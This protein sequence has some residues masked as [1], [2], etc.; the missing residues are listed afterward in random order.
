VPRPSTNTDKKLIQAAIDIMAGQGF[1]GLNIRQVARRARVNLGMF[2]YH[3]KTKDGFV[4]TVLQ[5]IYER[6]Y[7]QF[8]LE[9]SADAPLEER[10]RRTLM[11]ASCFI[12]DNRQNIMVILHGVLERDPVV[13]D[14][15]HK[16]FHR[17]ILL[18][19][20]L[21]REAQ[22]KGVIARLPIF[23]VVSFLMGGVLFPCAAIGA[24]ERAVEKEPM[25]LSIPLIRG[26]V[27]SDKAIQQRI[28]LALKALAPASTPGG[29]PASTPGGTPQG[30]KVR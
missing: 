5:E 2:H 7:R 16:N 9:T 14:F 11:M 19:F 22:R 28:D 27:I 24:I 21:I 13:L 25:A 3:F 18:V 26:Q 6:F 23:T 30:R 12:R 17:H 4:R 15:I 20:R 10:L 1:S 29:A 8:T